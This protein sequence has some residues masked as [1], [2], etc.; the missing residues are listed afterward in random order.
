MV[1][2]EKFLKEVDDASLIKYEIK[3]DYAA[4]LGLLG[5]LYKAI[6]NRNPKEFMEAKNMIVYKGGSPNPDSPSKVHQ[7]ANKF[8]DGIFLM[9]FLGMEKNFIF[10]MKER[11]LEIKF[12]N[13]K[14]YYEETLLSDMDWS[15]NKKRNKIVNEVWNNLF[16]EEFPDDEKEILTL[17]LNKAVSLQEE[18]IKLN[19]K[20]KQE[21]APRVEEECEVSSSSFNKSV[22]IKFSKL[23][24]KD[25]TK[26]IDKVKEQADAILE[27]IKILEE[28]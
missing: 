4:N 26:E 27:T 21:I 25:Y 2:K 13:E 9:R 7:L 22:S 20:I 28:E 15:S 11:G 19:D 6:F 8:A 12:I 17:M 23:R 5:K 18:M 3:N 16:V 24:G 14:S 1:N 10:H